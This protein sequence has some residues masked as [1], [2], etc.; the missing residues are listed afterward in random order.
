MTDTRKKLHDKVKVS[1]SE[2]DMIKNNN[3]LAKDL[4]A[5]KTLIYHREG[6]E[7]RLIIG[8]L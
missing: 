1:K 3:N 8:K 7:I 2:I 4:N 6:V 5:M